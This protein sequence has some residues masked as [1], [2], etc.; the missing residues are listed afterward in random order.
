[1]RY[2]FFYLKNYTHYSYTQNETVINF[3]Y[4]QFL[5]L[6]ELIEQAGSILWQIWQNK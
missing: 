2:F 3:K 1:M 6:F 5:N 4:P